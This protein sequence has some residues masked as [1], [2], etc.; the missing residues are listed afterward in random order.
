MAPVKPKAPAKPTT[1]DRVGNDARVA[2]RPQRGFHK[3]KDGS[4]NMK[5]KNKAERDES[6]TQAVML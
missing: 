4:L 6:V 3:Y 1:K 2:K 5:P